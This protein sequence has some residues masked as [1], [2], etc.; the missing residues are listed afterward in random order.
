MTYQQGEQAGYAFDDRIEDLDNSSIIFKIEDRKKLLLRI[1][2]KIWLTK[3]QQYI[4]YKDL[5]NTHLTN[6]INLLEK[7]E[8]AKNSILQLTLT[9][10]KKEQEKRNRE[11]TLNLGQSLKTPSPRQK[12]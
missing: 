5:G 10:L 9:A 1:K 8:P 7:N 3:D 6:I 2:K 4:K 11:T 12:K